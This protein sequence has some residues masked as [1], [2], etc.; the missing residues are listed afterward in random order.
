MLSNKNDGVSLLSF[1]SRIC[2][3]IA[4][5]TIGRGMWSVLNLA[6]FIR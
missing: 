5:W 3:A 4:R 1:N 6:R 2:T